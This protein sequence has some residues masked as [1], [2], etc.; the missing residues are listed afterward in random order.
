MESIRVYLFSG[1]LTVY[2][3]LH[4]NPPR[5]VIY[6]N[7]LSS[8]Q[9]LLKKHYSSSL[10]KLRKIYSFIT[11]YFNIPRITYIVKPCDL[12]HSTRGF[13]ILNRKPWVVDVETF[14][15]FT[16]FKIDKWKDPLYRHII[17]K[18][19]AS[20]HLKR[21]MVWSEIAR[22]GLIKTFDLREID[23]K[24]EVVYPALTAPHFKVR[25]SKDK[26]TILYVSSSFF[27]K[28]GKFVLETFSKLHQKYDVQLLMKCDV[29]EVF[30]KKFRNVDVKF[31]PYK[32]QILPRRELLQQFYF[33]SDIFFYP[34]LGD[35]FGLALLDA[36]CASL[37]I[38]STN[39]FAMPEI[40][41]DN[42]NGFI[43]NSPILWHDEWGIPRGIPIQFNSSTLLRF[44]AKLTEKLSLLIENS[45]LRKR[46]GRYG[47][48]L[49]EKGKFSIK[50]RNKKLLKIYQEALRY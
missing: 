46:M 4:N 39:V 34:S 17:K 50:E 24:I 30:R 33:K 36:M 27:R 48:R 29:P 16:G 41:E 31:F 26:V 32:S 9:N 21:I 7:K 35:T 11:A 28:G 6:V 8:P 15:N 2:T 45:S 23:D 13:I 44:K 14:G 12:I 1:G 37:P 10:M 25:R 5:D 49:V 40:V 42:R 47:R 19:L 18:F 22:R 38:I 3:D 20:Y 43:V